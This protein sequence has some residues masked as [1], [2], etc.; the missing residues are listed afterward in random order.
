MAEFRLRRRLSVIFDLHWLAASQRRLVRDNSWRGVGDRLPDIHSG[1]A[2]LLDRANELVRDE[3]VRATVA[4]RH[5]QGFRETLHV[6]RLFE[7]FDLHV[8]FGITVLVD[9]RL[10]IPADLNYR[11]RRFLGALH[12]IRKPVAKKLPSFSS[13][14]GYV[15]EDR[16]AARV[17]PGSFEEGCRVP[18]RV[19]VLIGLK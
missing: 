14:G 9:H 3:G 11:V 1:V 17:A 8:A 18:E 6:I 15:P 4:A 7:S 12:D 16:D 10:S 2:I 19:L 13:A 5:P